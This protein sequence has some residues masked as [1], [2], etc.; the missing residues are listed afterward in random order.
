MTSASS[1]SVLVS[2]PAAFERSRTPPLVVCSSMGVPPPFNL[3]SRR[4]RDCSEISSFTPAT[5][6]PPLVQDAEMS[7][8]ADS[9][10]VSETPPLVVRSAIRS[11][12]TD[13]SSMLTRPLVAAASTP[14]LRPLPVTPPLVVLAPGPCR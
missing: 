3:P 11:E 5:L 9:G 6:M 14:P 1:A 2:S 10:T 13:A 7:A 4:R 12:P 8:F